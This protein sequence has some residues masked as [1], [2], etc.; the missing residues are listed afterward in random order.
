MSDYVVEVVEID[1]VEKHPNADRL[2]LATIKGWQCV[3]SKDSFKDG[4]RAIYIP[5]DSIIPEAIECTLFPLGSKV[6]LHKSRVRTIKLRGAISQGMLVKPA[7][8]GLDTIKVGKDVKD[9]L[10]IIKYEP[11]IN[12]G[13][14]SLNTAKSTKRNQ[15]KNFNKYTKI[16]NY[17][18]YPE[19]FKEG[20]EVVITEKIH[21]TNFRAGWVKRDTSKWYNKLARF[22]RFISEY[23]FVYGS[24]NVQLQNKFLWKGFYDKNVYAEAVKIYNLEN[25]LEKGYVIYGEIYGYGIQKNYDYGFKDSGH[26]LRIF[27]IQKD[28]KYL[29]AEDCIEQC[30]IFGLPHVPV[31]YIGEY[32]KDNAKKLSTGGSVID[33]ANKVIEGVVIKPLKEQQSYAGRKILKL[34]NDNYLLLKDNSEFH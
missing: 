20:D 5:I 32:N 4:D 17:K 24:H 9:I 25:R 28:G 23:E 30:K 21:G 12:K 22:F 26:A 16:S 6:K 8:F 3:V 15:N 19:L 29:D 18:N 1:K 13:D 27:D 14:G 2:D 33:P 10:G 34:I 7:M 11:K 31:L